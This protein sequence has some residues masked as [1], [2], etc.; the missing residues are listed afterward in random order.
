MSSGPIKGKILIY[1]LKEL[2]L[3]MVDVQHARKE[4]VRIQ[5]QIHVYNVKIV[6]VLIHILDIIPNVQLVKSLIVIHKKKKKK[7]VLFQMHNFFRKDR[8]LVHSK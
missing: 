2:M 4:K 8:T 5:Q 3:Q 6:K 7:K 1:L